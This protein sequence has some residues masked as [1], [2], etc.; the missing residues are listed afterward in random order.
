M[1]TLVPKLGRTPG[2]DGR[3]L[4][5]VAPHEVPHPASVVAE[6]HLLGGA[7]D[8]SDLAGVFASRQRERDERVADVLLAASAEPAP[9]KR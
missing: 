9:A 2:E 7:A 3:D 5:P 4:P 6:D 8:L 1:P